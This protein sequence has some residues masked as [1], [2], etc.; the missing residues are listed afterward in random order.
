MTLKDWGTIAS[1]LMA[2][3]SLISVAVLLY[4]QFFAGPRLSTQ[5]SQVVLLR[6][7]GINKSNLIVDMLLDDLLSDEPSQSARAIISANEGIKTAIEGRIRPLLHGQL[8]EMQRGS[9]GKKFTY[10]PQVDRIETYMAD[11][12][13]ALSFAI[14]VVVYNTG[15]RPAHVSSLV[16]T[17]KKKDDLSQVWAFIP[18]VELSEGTLL[19]R[20]TGVSDQERFEKLFVGFAV[21][22]NDSVRTMPVFVPIKQ[23]KGETI[24]NT[25]MLPGDY[26]LELFGYDSKNAL[27]FRTN[28][29]D[30]SLIKEQVIGTF[31]GREAVHYLN[32]EGAAS[33]AVEKSK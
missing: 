27:L 9:E 3:I 31:L 17:V 14:P 4:D 5:L 22:P 24:S 29:M 19:Q 16:L 23:A 28:A 18:F 25:N 30:F 1:L 20:S 13:F 7:P 2:L 8:I 26:L 21:G 15:K 6:L 32:T 12:R 33:D 10:D 11:D